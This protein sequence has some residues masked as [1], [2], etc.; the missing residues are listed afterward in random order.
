MLVNEYAEKGEP[1]NTLLA[2]GATVI[3]MSQRGR[4]LL[5]RA[6]VY[7]VANAMSV[8]ETVASA[9]SGVAQSAERVASSA[10][11]LAGDLVGEAQQARQGAE[12]PHDGTQK[13]G[14]PYG[15]QKQGTPS[16][17][18]AQARRPRQPR[19]QPKPPGASP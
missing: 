14:T 17:T 3:V 2:A 7:G 4:N 9:A 19:T 18:R 16:D 8:G 6:V 15:T 5:R 1:M 10:G 13:Q 12:Q 11:D